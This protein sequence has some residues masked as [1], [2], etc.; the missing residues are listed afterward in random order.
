[1]SP[2]S[3]VVDAAVVVAWGRHGVSA[4]AAARESLDRVNV[5]P[6][7]DAD[8]GT[9]MYLTL[10]DAV[11]ALPADSTSG[12]LE[13]GTAGG[14]GDLLVRLARGALVGARGNSGVILSEYLR[15]LALE[16]AEHR[17]VT[18]AALAAGLG[19]AART[20]RGAVAR[21]A[22]GTILTAADAAA[23]T[24]ATASEGPDVSSPAVVA[25]AARDGAR[26]AA[27]RS[28]GELDVLARAQVLDAGALG[29]VLV[30]GALVA[31][32]GAGTAVP[33]DLG[34]TASAADRGVAAHDDAGL[35]GA[36][37]SEVLGMMAGMVP[38]P[39][40][41][42]ESGTAPEA[43][44]EGGEFEVMYVV[45][46][47]VGSAAPAAG[48]APVEDPAGLLRAELARIGDS[49]VVVG[50]P[51]DRGSGLW[52]AHVH[53]DD[54]MAAVA[55]GRAALVTVRHPLDDGAARAGGE[56]GGEAALR[57]V[58]V[59]HLPGSHEH[60]H[61][62][63][64]DT[65]R[66]P[67]AGA[68]AIPVDG[69]GPGLVAVTT[70]P[71]LVADLARAGAVVLLREAS[72]PLDLAALHR[73]AVDARAAHVALLP[74]ADLPEDDVEALRA[75]LRDDGVET[76]EVLP[77]ATDLH[78]AVALAAAQL[79]EHGAAPRLEAAR[80]ALDAVRWSRLDVAGVPAPEA[81]R[82]LVDLADPLRARPGALVTVLADD[83][84]PDAAVDALAADA[85]GTGAEVVLLRSGRGGGGVTLAV[86]GPDALETV[87]ED[88]GGTRDE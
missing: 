50:G 15:G 85:T 19:R 63:E 2:R 53:T 83:D 27:L 51:G 56:A 86:E 28:T 30:L 87:D 13:E 32:I 68:G 23:R 10:L 54:P 5:F 36:G 84:V 40:S 47:P 16:L 14:A 49:V 1:M 8:T 25:A 88:T 9:N 24:A 67:G 31:A 34:A 57:Q 71:G 35:A 72:V 21:P 74:G 44:H 29:L 45:D 4:L 20:A 70:A 75:S 38:V 26:A 64:A 79:V 37:V 48:R 61:G 3:D 46:A 60:N 81:A 39:G 62:L 12:A 78:V 52:Q 69:G 6:V 17:T 76:L 41:S 42:G 82:R 18:G 33:T 77:A 43:G 73:V 80:S 55:V 59:R 11:R 7:A 65:D 22:P 58:R 66:T